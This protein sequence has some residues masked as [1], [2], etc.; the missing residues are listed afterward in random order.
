MSKQIVII[1]GGPAGIEA[2]REAV[3]AG[4]RVALVSNAPLGGRAGWHSLSPSKVWLTT[5]DTLGLFAEADALGLHLETGCQPNLA[6]ILARIQEITTAWN[7]EQ[8]E[9]LREL[10]VEM[11]TGT[12]VFTQPHELAIKD[13]EGNVTATLTADAFIVATGS[14]PRFPPQMK[15]DGKRVIAP[16]FA[17]HLQAIP[18]SIVVV[19]G[20]ATGSEFA[21]L[22]NRVGTAVTWIV[23][24]Q[25]VLPSFRPDVGRF[26]AEALVKQGVKLV[27]GQL[28]QR[29]DRDEEKV[30]VILADGAAYEAEMAFLAI[31]RNPD[32]TGINLAAAGLDGGG[33]PALDEYGRTPNPSIYIVGDAAGDP[34]IANRAMAQARIAA[35]HALGAPTPPY[36]PET[37]VAATYTEPQA[38]QVGNVAPS[39]N[40]GTAR[41]PF[42]AVLKARLL[43]HNEGFVEL[44]YEKD[45]LRVTGATAVGPH[46]ADV[47]APVAPALEKE[48]AIPD[49]AAIYPAHPTLSEL[50]FMAARAVIG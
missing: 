5:A 42:T 44:A 11:I 33:V 3:R 14:V 49:L 36:R 46:A 45:S 19:G 8:A 2:A 4:G 17:K 28:A 1:G 50:V 15:P 16:R 20:G 24:D 27:A 41:L 23:D 38:A 22:F 48:A 26:L 40:V 6:G 35:R 47:L 43:A 32:L 7:T 25:G 37:V 13:K 39:D 31:G 10:G 12:A 30:R 29:I 9:E 21:Y 18:R 34:M